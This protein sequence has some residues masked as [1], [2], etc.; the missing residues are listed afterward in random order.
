MG[1]GPAGR[2]QS[3]VCQSPT[4]PRHPPIRLSKGSCRSRCGDSRIRNC[5]YGSEAVSP[6]F[7]S[8]DDNIVRVRIDHLPQEAGGLFRER[9]ARRTVPHCDSEGIVRAPLRSA[10]GTSGRA[11]AAGCGTRRNCGGTRAPRQFYPVAMGNSI[12]CVVRGIGVRR[13]VAAQS[14]VARG[15]YEGYESGLGQ[16]CSLPTP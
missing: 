11:A 14:R 2:R 12:G 3:P 6:T 4:A 10:V 15:D 8:H 5:L 9:R 1:T 16:K 13:L 7:N